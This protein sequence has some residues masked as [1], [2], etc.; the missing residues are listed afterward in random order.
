MPINNKTL[1][2]RKNMTLYSINNWKSLSNMDIKDFNQEINSY[3]ER[4]YR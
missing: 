3:P 2:E 4:L 1:I